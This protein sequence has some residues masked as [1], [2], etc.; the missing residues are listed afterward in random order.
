[1]ES[2]QKQ[3]KQSKIVLTGSKLKT[4]PPFTKQEKITESLIDNLIGRGGLP[5]T[6]T[7]KKWFI[8]FMADNFKTALMEEQLS[9]FVISNEEKELL[10]NL[11]DLLMLF[12][13]A[14][15]VLQREVIPLLILLERGLVSMPQTQPSL[16]AVKEALLSTF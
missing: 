8:D 10:T 4:A 14:T 13:D 5:V 2:E 11:A 9:E 15:N 3:S 6:L 1:M 16:N 12:F 7:T